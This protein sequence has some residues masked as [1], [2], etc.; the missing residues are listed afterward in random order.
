MDFSK[1]TDNKYVNY[2]SNVCKE[3]IDEKIMYEFLDKMQEVCERFDT[4]EV[5]SPI[6][7]T[8]EIKSRLGLN[9]PSLYDNIEQ[10]AESDMIDSLSSLELYA[11]LWMVSCRNHFTYQEKVYYRMA[12]NKTIGKLLRKL[13]LQIA[14]YKM[15]CPKK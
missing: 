1:I 3:S 4:D 14:S 9:G 11:L 5:M 15:I 6:E 8:K 10:I 13:S 2:F 12:A 7:I